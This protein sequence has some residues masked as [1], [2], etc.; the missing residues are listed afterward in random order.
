MLHINALNDASLILM[1]QNGVT[2]TFTTIAIA[3]G[4]AI[5]N[6]LAQ[7]YLQ[8]TKRTTHDRTSCHT[9]YKRWT[10]KKS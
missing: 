6:V 5:P 9:S 3:I 1:I 2:G 7:K 8:K 4:V 10:V